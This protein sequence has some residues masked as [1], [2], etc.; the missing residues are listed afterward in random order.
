LTRSL[1][2]LLALMAP[3]V[4]GDALAAENFACGAGGKPNAKT[5]TCDCPPGKVEKTSGGTS[6]CVEVASKPPPTPTVVAPPPSTAPPAT[7]KCPPGKILHE[8]GCVDLC[9]PD[10]QWTFGKCTPRCTPDEIWINDRCEKAKSAPKCEAPKIADPTGHC[11]W[12]GQ[13]WGEESHRCRGVPACPQGYEVEGEACVFH[14][15]KGMHR[16]GKGFAHCCWPGQEWSAQ[17]QACVGIASCPYGYEPSADGCRKTPPKCEPGKAS[18]DDE[19]CCWPGQTWSDGGTKKKKQD[20]GCTGT[21]QC[22]A[23]L[24]ALGDQCVPQADLDKESSRLAKI[25]RATYL[26]APIF[27]NALE[28]LY[29]RAPITTQVFAIGYMLAFHPVDLPITFRGGLIIGGYAGDLP[30]VAPDQTKKTYYE[31]HIGAALS[32][33]SIP[34]AAREPSS[35]LNPFVGFDFHGYAYT[36]SNSSGG[37]RGTAGTLVIGNHIY[38]RPAEE[39]KENKTNVTLGGTFELSI[40]GDDTRPDMRIMLLFGA[41]RILL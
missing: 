3:I 25:E 14:C 16:T 39:K 21:P 20:D 10:E 38:L 22:P 17:I 27:I 34:N 2:Y 4:L 6:R 23:G 28:L 7:P 29:G 33:L 35:Y 18:P 1:P 13:V 5:A 37:R 41:G 26:G 9:A 30:Q 19:H 11:C 31:Y 12:S 8:G 40:F 15:P 36:N 24:A 32:P